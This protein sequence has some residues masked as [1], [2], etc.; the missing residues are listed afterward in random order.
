MENNDPY[1]GQ[2]PFNGHTPLPWFI[3]MKSSYNRPGITGA[4]GAP[5]IY[6]NIEG[7]PETTG[8]GPNYGSD[9]EFIYEAVSKYYPHLSAL[10][11]YEIRER[12]LREALELSIGTIARLVVAGAA[13]CDDL[14]GPK[15]AAE[16]EGARSIQRMQ[17][18][19]YKADNSEVL[20]PKL[21]ALLSGKED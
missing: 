17:D 4:R 12:K 14:E 19:W 8:L 7:D 13:M 18:A 2:K 21:R 15:G 5:V 16:P 11:A 10:Q 1:C 6:Q 20:L 9:A 3:R